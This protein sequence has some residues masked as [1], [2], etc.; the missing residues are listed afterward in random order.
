MAVEHKW[1]FGVAEDTLVEAAEKSDT[2]VY[3]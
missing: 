3:T 1:T 2:L